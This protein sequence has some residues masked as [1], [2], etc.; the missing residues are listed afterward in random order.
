MTSSMD[1]ENDENVY[2]LASKNDDFDSGGTN[3]SDVHDNNEDDDMYDERTL[4]N[5]KQAFYIMVG[6]TIGSGILIMPNIIRQLGVIYWLAVLFIILLI[7]LFVT[8]IINKS[9]THVMDQTDDVTEIIRE[10]YQAIAEKCGGIRLR[11]FSVFF[12]YFCNIFFSLSLFLLAANILATFVPIGEFG[13]STRTRIWMTIIIIVVTP[14]MYLG[15]YSNL[16]VPAI[17]ATVSSLL[18]ALCI[19]VNSFLNLFL[20]RDT[21]ARE[22][23]AKEALTRGEVFLTVGTILFTTLGTSLVM[24]NIT[25]LSTNPKQV[26]RPI[27]GSIC[28]IGLCLTLMGLIP[29]YAFDGIV[30]PSILTTFEHVIRYNKEVIA[31]SSLTMVVELLMF[32]HLM[33]AAILVLNPVFL[34]LEEFLSI[35]LGE[36][37][38]SRKYAKLRW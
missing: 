23:V 11:R 38:S 26:S 4:I 17:T 36:Y 3:K 9:V 20:Y 37:P 32:I 15:T 28:V 24:P 8:Y 29:Y 2:L 13:I 7:Q 10:P 21:T 18:S 35:P 27:I 14:I 6:S 5:S 30:S 16:K 34:H 25:V 22:S 33:M 1:V 12:M 31:F 19:I